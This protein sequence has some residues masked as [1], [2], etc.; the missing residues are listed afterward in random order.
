MPKK[1]THNPYRTKLA[2]GSTIERDY[3]LDEDG[4]QVP[5]GNWKWCVYDP[6]R[7]P[8]TKKVNLR[9]RDKGAALQK[10]GEYVRLR[11][12]GA[13]DP[14]KDHAPLDGVTLP[15]AAE[16]YLQ[17]KRRS[18]KSP[19]TV[20]TDRGHLDRFARSLPVGFEV[21][22]VEKRHVEAFVN[23][24]GRGGNSPTPAYRQRVRASLQHF[25]GWA[26]GRG[27]CR[28][29]PTEGVKVPKGRMGRRDHVTE[30]EV[31]AI[32]AA[33]EEA[34]AK[35]G[36]PRGWLK[37]WVVFAFGTGFRPGEQR[38]LKW[39]AVSL[40]E[41][42]VQVGRGH[43]TKTAKSGR[44]VHVRGDALRVLERR[45]A[46]FTEGGHV[47]TGADG[48]PVALDYT[49]KQVK[50]FAR[51]AGVR[52]NITDYSLRHGFGT[53]MAQAGVPLWELSQMMGT[54]V[55]MLELH[56][57]HHDPARAAAYVERVY[58]VAA[59]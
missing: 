11:G 45:A 37:D 16:Q 44:V 31:R 5:S 59:T 36:A 26:M 40:S 54:S 49:T 14:W 56:Y 53:R 51:E 1:R 21:Q 46:A 34:E 22:H 39:E 42:T 47:F 9:T 6:T 33:I 32:I 52:K 50:R 15:V 57:A 8:R 10:A 3:R 18:G 2:D 17:H 4:R 13:L 20:E 43:G 23:R 29:N 24:P 35:T 30:P 38:E 27:L 25:F 7:W 41:R 48:G 55:R 28:T 58:G 12:T 19:A